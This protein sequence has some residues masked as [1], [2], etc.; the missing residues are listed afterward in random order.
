MPCKVTTIYWDSA[1]G[2][3][4]SC[5]LGRCFSAC[6][7]LVKDASKRCLAVFLL[8]PKVN[9][10]ASQTQFLGYL[11]QFVAVKPSP[12]REFFFLQAQV[13]AF[14]ACHETHH[15]SDGEGPR[16]ASEIVWRMYFQPG[17]FLYFA[18][19]GIFKRLSRFYK[20]SNKAV[21][22]AFEVLGMYQ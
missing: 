3:V 17:F 21:E 10:L 9:Q 11:R 7:E 12:S 4:F 19:D 14:I 5:L 15:Q 13:S 18:H 6:G 2:R 8:Q 22:V 20:A 1:F 16:L